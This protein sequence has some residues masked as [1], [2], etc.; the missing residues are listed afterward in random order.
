MKENRVVIQKK[1]NGD[2]RLN[3]SFNED[4]EAIDALLNG[5]VVL[6]TAVMEQP[7]VNPQALAQM[8]VTQFTAVLNEKVSAL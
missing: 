8:T 3:H 4:M 1:K 7:E 6:L 5:A 2:L